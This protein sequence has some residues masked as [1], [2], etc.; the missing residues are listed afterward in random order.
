MGNNA[1]SAT[2]F[3]QEANEMDLEFVNFIGKYQK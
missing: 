3:I 1:P 2:N